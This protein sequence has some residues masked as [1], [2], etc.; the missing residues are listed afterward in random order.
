M[1]DINSPLMAGCF[2]I[3]IVTLRESMRSYEQIIVYKKGVRINGE[4]F[5]YI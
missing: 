1:I 5:I 2:F 3:V 4:K